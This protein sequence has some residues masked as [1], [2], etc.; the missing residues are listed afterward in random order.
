[1]SELFDLAIDLL[2][3]DSG[4]NL[5]RKRVFTPGFLVFCL[6]VVVVELVVLN[7]LY[8]NLG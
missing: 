3:L 8:G 1:M 6:V 4:Q 2:D 5:R 7:S